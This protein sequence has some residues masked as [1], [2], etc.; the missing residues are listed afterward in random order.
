[1]KKVEEEY[2]VDMR[3]KVVEMRGM[4]EAA[5][6]FERMNAHLKV[7]LKER[8]FRSKQ[9]ILQVLL[10]ARACRKASMKI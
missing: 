5:A 2:T 10:F 1:M 3:R 7:E 9:N 6:P 8:N 4:K